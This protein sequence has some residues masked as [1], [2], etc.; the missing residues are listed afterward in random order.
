[1]NLK[2]LREE[3]G[4]KAYKVAEKLYISRAQLSNIE[5][6]KYNVDMLK[7]E[8]LS[9][10]YGKSIEEIEMACEVTRCER[11]RNNI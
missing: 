3:S 7:K 8:K 11:R 9:K 2:Q 6:G 5:S 1:M 10:I 4:I